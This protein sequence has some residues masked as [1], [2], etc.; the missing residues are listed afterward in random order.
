MW[1]LFLYY[2]GEKWVVLMLTL[3]SF[4]FHR[5]L[6]EGKWS[7]LGSDSS[8]SGSL[9]GS[10]SENK[11]LFSINIGMIT[12]ITCY[13]SMLW[14]RSWIINPNLMG[15]DRINVWRDFDIINSN[16]KSCSIPTDISFPIET[17]INSCFDKHNQLHSSKRN[18]DSNQWWK[19]ITLTI[20]HFKES[21]IVLCKWCESDPENEMREE[22]ECEQ[23]LE[24]IQINIHVV[25]GEELCQAAIIS[26]HSI[27]MKTW[28]P[29]QQ[30]Q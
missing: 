14:S 23:E 6:W 27:C 30:Q 9:I 21:Y 10:P 2:I 16:Q 13:K 3:T 7:D 29:D 24:E 17:V 20:L 18:I 22:C 15:D 5:C 28:F 1:H 26:P 4:V 8:D 12:N 11:Y 25:C 19:Q